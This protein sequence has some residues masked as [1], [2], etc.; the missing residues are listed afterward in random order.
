MIQGS[1][2]KTMAM[3][4]G[5]GATIVGESSYAEQRALEIVDG[6]SRMWQVPA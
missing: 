4:R 3:N 6:S 2:N 1:Q 5:F